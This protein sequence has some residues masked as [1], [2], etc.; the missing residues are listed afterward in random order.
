MDPR[1]II[2]LAQGCPWSSW[3]PPDLKHCEENL[4]SWITAPANTWS[5]LAYILIGIWLWRTARG[6]R[7][8]SWRK[9]FGPVEIV[10]GATSLAFHASYTFCFQ[11]FDYAGMFLFLWLLLVLNLRRSVR[12]SARGQMV[13]FW[14]GLSLSLAAFLAFRALHL[15]V[16]NLFAA[17]VAGLLLWEAGL[18]VAGQGTRYRDYVYT[19]MLMAAAF[20]FWMLDYTRV[21]CDPGNHF[22]QGHAAW[23]VISAFAFI[24]AYRFYKQFKP[25]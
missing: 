19:M 12:V 13:F 3:A 1:T 10:V 8:G 20:A 14:G 18:W 5:N 9:W 2:P 11:F 6:A 17:G 15:P 16:Q 22:F 24:T 25:A 21:V 23:H 4:C 7:D